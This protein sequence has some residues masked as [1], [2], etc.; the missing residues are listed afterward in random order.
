MGGGGGSSSSAT[1]STENQTTTTATS[2][3][4]TGY[5]FQAQDQTVYPGTDAATVQAA[6]DATTANLANGINLIAQT[7]TGAAD[8][9]SKALGLTAAVTGA[10]TQIVSDITAPIPATANPATQTATPIDLT[11]MTPWIIG[12]GIVLYLVTKK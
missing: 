10:G 4:N 3:G 12:G 7:Q 2:T 9:I 1:T 11:K 5:V 8:L 6:L